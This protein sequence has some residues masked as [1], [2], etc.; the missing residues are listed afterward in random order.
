M[1]WLNVKKAFYSVPHDWIL[2]YLKLFGV[3]TKIIRFLAC[4]MCQWFTVLTVNGVPLGKV[5]INC[6]I[7][8]ETVSHLCYLF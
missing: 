5:D 7:F 2:Y 3:H 8:R 1:A 4:A 6:G